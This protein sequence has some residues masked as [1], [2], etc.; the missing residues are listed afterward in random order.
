M[1]K[2]KKLSTLLRVFFLIYQKK[3]C[4]YDFTPYKG[5]LFELNFSPFDVPI[6]TKIS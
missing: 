3:T 6:S 1:E 5:A 2:I 4:H